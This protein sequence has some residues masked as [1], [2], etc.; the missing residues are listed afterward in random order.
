MNISV[1]IPTYNEGKH[2]EK[3]LK[4]IGKQEI[5]IVEAGSTLKIAKKYKAKVIKSKKR[6]R[7]YQLN[8]GAKQAKGDYLLFLHADCILP[9]NW[10]TKLQDSWGGFYI[11]FRSKDP[12]F[13]LVEWRSN[14]LRTDITKIFFGD[15]GIYVKKELFKKVNGFPEEPIMEDVLFC[16]KL[17]EI[18]EPYVITDP[19]ETS[20]RRFLENGKY[21][22]YF[23]MCIAMI[24]YH[25]RF[26]CK[27]I[28]KAYLALQ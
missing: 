2:L 11:K 9:K 4:A 6:N 15:Q 18:E 7:A 20:P 16:K 24:L 19:I 17:R 3:T 26:S 21:K 23:A 28:K 8:L 13:K 22:T 12:F 14:K 27:T 10:D 5:I 25:L 1:I